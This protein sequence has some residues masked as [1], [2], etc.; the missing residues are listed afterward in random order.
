MN[1]GS[2]LFPYP[3]LNNE[4]LFSQFKQASFALKYEE[5][6]DENRSL[7]IFKNIHC[8]LLS[9]YFL[10]LIAKKLVKVVCVI[11]CAPTMFRK[12]Y[13]IGTSNRDIEVSLYDLN[14]KVSVSAFIVAVQD[15]EYKSDDFL[16]D[17]SDYKFN[18]EKNYILA[19]DDG[20]T[21]RVDFNN[22]EDSKKSSIFIVIKNKKI[23]DESML[24]SYDSNKIRIELPENQFNHYEKT[25]QIKKFTNLYFSLLV[26]PAL[27][28][29]LTQLRKDGVDVD[30]LRIENSWFNAFCIAY[31]KLNKREVD[32]QLFRD[33]DVHYES[34]KIFNMP[35]TKALDDLFNLTIGSFGGDDDEN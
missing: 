12:T 24:V 9:D 30:E 2:R 19:V 8:E 21:N 13:E 7:Y 32:N 28:I 27:S 10:S 33:M 31:E 23:K 6:I 20:F 22:E 11:E 26:I 14:G 5:F 25:K 4:K 29:C 17:Y 15:F 18:I 3:L 35:V 34:Q 16:E 1:I